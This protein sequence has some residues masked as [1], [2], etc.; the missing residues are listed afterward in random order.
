MAKE[1][2]HFVLLDASHVDDA[3]VEQ[4]RA[5]LIVQKQMD[6]PTA[7]HLPAVQIRYRIWLDN[8]D[9]SLAVHA[10]EGWAVVGM[11][12]LPEMRSLLYLLQRDAPLVK[13]LAQPPPG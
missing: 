7:A 5:Q 10:R 9:A 12:T 1:H 6:A 11:V 8:A 13:K 4:A 2:M 3:A